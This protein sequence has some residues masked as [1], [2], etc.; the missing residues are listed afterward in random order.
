MTASQNPTLMISSPPLASSDN[1][2]LASCIRLLEWALALE[3]D[4]V[5]AHG[6]LAWCNQFLFIPSRLR[7]DRPH[8][9]HSSGS[10]GS[11][12]WPR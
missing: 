3:A 7:G 12:P 10:R 11:H 4:D 2:A 1:G 9:R 8:R 6:L 5:A